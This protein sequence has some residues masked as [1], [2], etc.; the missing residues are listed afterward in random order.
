MG[1]LIKKQT[2]VVSSATTLIIIVPPL[3]Y[4]QLR[5][6]LEDKRLVYQTEQYKC[7]ERGW[8]MRSSTTETLLTDAGTAPLRDLRGGEGLSYPQSVFI[9]VFIVRR[10]VNNGL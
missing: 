1:F 9:M 6:G 7:F 8:A 5:L 4:Q 2:S 3:R 10:F